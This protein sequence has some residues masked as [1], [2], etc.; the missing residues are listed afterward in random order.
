LTIRPPPCRHFDPHNLAL[1]RFDPRTFSYC[2]TPTPHESDCKAA[3]KPL[4]LTLQKWVKTLAVRVRSMS[5]HYRKLSYS[6]FLLDRWDI[7]EH[8]T[9]M[10]HIKNSMVSLDRTPP[11][12]GSAG[13]VH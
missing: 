8:S 6:L 10:A 1:Q 9:Q 11:M 13:C 12:H 3:P 5:W 2:D 7:A 4:S